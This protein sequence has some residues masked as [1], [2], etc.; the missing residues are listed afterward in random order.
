[1]FCEKC[2]LSKVITFAGILIIFSM[3]IYH[4]FF[5]KETWQGII[6]SDGCLNC[7]NQVYSPVFDNSSDCRRWILSNKKSNDDAECAK[8]CKNPDEYGMLICDE[9]ID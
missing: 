5:A 3:G 7:D 8:N 6:Y 1:M 2:R 9:T 4:I